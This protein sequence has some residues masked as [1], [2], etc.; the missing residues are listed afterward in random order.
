MRRE[1]TREKVILL[2]I[3]SFVGAFFTGAAVSGGGLPIFILLLPLFVLFFFVY[4]FM[5]VTGIEVKKES[6][7]L[8]E[9]HMIEQRKYVRKL[10][11]FFNKNSSRSFSAQKVWEQPE[12]NHKKLVSLE[13]ELKI[14]AMKKVLRVVKP[15]NPKEPME[16]TK[17]NS[18]WFYLRYP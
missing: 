3:A 17:N 12:F 9:P 6:W 16:Y 1:V 4:G 2:T 18:L 13:F 15:I 14:L 10:K 7:G 5:A 11:A 8:L